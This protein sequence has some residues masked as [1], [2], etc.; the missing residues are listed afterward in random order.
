[1]DLAAGDTL[2]FECDIVNDTQ[3]TFVGQ[4]EAMNDEMCIM[5][6]DTV[7]TNV[8]IVCTATDIPAN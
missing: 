8:P 3:N 5:I 4:N 7:G 6:G 2:D 1:M